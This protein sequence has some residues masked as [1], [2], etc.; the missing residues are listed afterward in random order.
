MI[1]KQNVLINYIQ[2]KIRKK[3]LIH[4]KFFLCLEQLKML[5]FRLKNYIQRKKI[6]SEQR[7]DNSLCLNIYNCLLKNK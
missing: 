3:M 6:L 1:L 7:E 4:K 2:K 5:E